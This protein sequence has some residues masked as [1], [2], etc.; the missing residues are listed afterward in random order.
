MTH[1]KFTAQNYISNAFILDVLAVFPFGFILQMLTKINYSDPQS[2]DQF[3]HSFAV[4]T[5]FKLLQMYRVP[6]AFAYF[7]RDPMKRKGVFL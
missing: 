6:D 1:P 5:L 7:Q 2:V 3:Y 4:L